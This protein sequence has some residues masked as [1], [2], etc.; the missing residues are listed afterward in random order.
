MRFAR[1]SWPIYNQMEVEQE[2]RFRQLKDQLRRRPRG[3]RLS[4]YKPNGLAL[5]RWQTSDRSRW[6]NLLL[7]PLRPTPMNSTH[8]RRR[9]QKDPGQ[10]TQRVAHLGICLCSVAG[11]AWP[12]LRNFPWNSGR[13]RSGVLG[14]R[15]GTGDKLRRS[16]GDKVASTILFD[17]GFTQQPS[18]TNAFPVRYNLN[19]GKLPRPS[20]VGLFQQNAVHRVERP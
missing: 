13:I 16:R 4:C 2:F 15:R 7:R 6:C 18:Q 3:G 10:H 9:E 12:D 5:G 8:Y 19:L 20:P 11:R 14:L 1:R 17:G